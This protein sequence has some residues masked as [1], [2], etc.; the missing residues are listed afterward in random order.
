MG[1]FAGRFKVQREFVSPLEVIYLPPVWVLLLRLAFS[2]SSERHMPMWSERN[3]LSLE[4]AIG[5]IE[6]LD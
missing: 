3:C 1:P 6:P 5:E 4:T 2:V